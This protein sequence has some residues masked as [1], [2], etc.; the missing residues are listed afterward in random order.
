MAQ[1]F[2]NVSYN[3]EIPV[4]DESHSVNHSHHTSDHTSH[5]TSHHVLDPRLVSLKNILSSVELPVIEKTDSTHSPEYPKYIGFKEPDEHHP[6]R[7][8]IYLYKEKKY[9]CTW[10]ITSGQRTKEHLENWISV[11]E[12]Y[13]GGWDECWETTGRGEGG[14]TSKMLCIDTMKMYEVIG[15]LSCLMYREHKYIDK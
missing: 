5:R 7:L 15:V 4:R 12:E 9:I 13:C 6:K 2:A 14:Y 1:A 11:L 3:Q 10:G 8:G